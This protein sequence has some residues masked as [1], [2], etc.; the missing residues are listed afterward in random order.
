MN[1]EVVEQQ[2]GEP[3]KEEVPHQPGKPEPDQTMQGTMTIVLLNLLLVVLPHQLLLLL[4]NT[5]DWGLALQS[6]SR[7]L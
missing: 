3:E 2:E 5:L 1:A 6:E 7:V 4:C